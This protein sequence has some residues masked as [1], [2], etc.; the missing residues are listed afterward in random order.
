MDGKAVVKGSL[1]VGASEN[2]LAQGSSSALGA[3]HVG[4]A[5]VSV[6]RSSLAKDSSSSIVLCDFWEAEVDV[7][8]HQ[9][10]LSGYRLVALRIVGE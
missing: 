8:R 5:V 2:G 3:D 7:G 9:P 1:L 4:L 10:A 6:C